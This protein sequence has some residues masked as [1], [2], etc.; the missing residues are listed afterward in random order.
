MVSII[1]LTIS[2]K[3]HTDP[4]HVE[5]VVRHSRLVLDRTGLMPAISGLLGHAPEHFCSS[6]PWGSTARELSSAEVAPVVVVL[7]CVPSLCFGAM[8][9]NRIPEVFKIVSHNP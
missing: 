4:A 7:L 6:R 3:E 5:L 1:P 2:A 9:H 8:E